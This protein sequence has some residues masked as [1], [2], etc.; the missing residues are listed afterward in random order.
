MALNPQWTLGDFGNTIAA[1]GALGTAAFGLVDAT[2]VYRGGVSNVGF[3]FIRDAVAPYLPAL[4]L[5]NPRDPYAV[6]LANWL[7]GVAKPTQ[8]ATAKSL[9]RL[10]TTSATAPA[11]AAAAPGVKP[12]ALISAAAKLESGQPLTQDDIDIL[13]RFDAILDA[14]MDTGFERADQKYRN[15]ARVLAACIA[16][17]LALIGVWLIEGSN[18][19]APDFL[20]ALFVGII[21][22]PLAPIAKDLSSAIGTAVAALKGNKG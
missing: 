6:I 18:V 15:F 1:I 17:A 8:K 10:G 22:T 9:I 21:S 11:L 7:N 3:N 2:K 20:M 12:M 13:G 16:I 14:Q 4:Q 19:K 5:V